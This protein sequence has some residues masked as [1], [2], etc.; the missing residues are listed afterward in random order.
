MLYDGLVAFRQAPGAAGD[1][2]V[3]DLAASIPSPTDGGRTYAFRLRHGIRWSTGAPVTGGDVRRG[4]ERLV[5][6]GTAPDLA[7]VGADACTPAACDLS[8]GVAV[9]DTTGTVTIRLSQAEP[10]FLQ[11][12]AQAVAFPP[13]T[14]LAAV[15]SPLPVTGPY[16]VSSYRPDASLVLVRN[17]HFREWSHAAQPA[18]YPDRFVFTMD[19][20][21][22]QDPDADARRPGF[23]WIDVRGADL[24]ALRARAGERLHTSPRLVVRYLFLNTS[25]PPFDVLAARRAVSYAI[26]RAAVAADWPGAAQVTCQLLPPT[27]PGYRPYCPYTLRPDA[28]GAWHAPDV[29]TAQRLVQQSGTTG[30]SVTVY[31]TP[32]VQRGMQPV[33]DA[34]NQI[35][36][37]A[38]LVTLST[39][40]YFSYL[41]QHPDVQAG[42]D[43]WIGAYPAASQFADMT[44][45]AAID[46]GSSFSHFCDPAVDATISSA[47]D[48]EAQSPQVASDTWATVDRTI[49]DAAPLVPLLVDGN[50]VLVSPRL[51]HYEVDPSG[52]IF[53]EGWLR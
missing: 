50:A 33:V 13:S 26:D 11:N 34:M 4:I 40:D 9:D 6:A 7:I 3:P 2:V 5:A 1:G 39:N 8:T 53:D 10:E 17:P 51:R 24:D 18:G 43:G 30:A 27:V 49:T 29:A 36:Y 42:F 31:T 46:G 23:D 35:G 22:G 16:E 14:P 52:P 48:L 25:V 32:L 37:H 12:L 41:E 47:L 45:C 44:T 15:D 28:S 21:W 20:S 38:T 19:P